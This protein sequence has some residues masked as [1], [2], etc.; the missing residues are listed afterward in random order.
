M[1]G[2]PDARSAMA[3]C[4]LDPRP[5]RSGVIPFSRLLRLAGQKRARTPCAQISSYTAPAG[6]SHH[7]LRV[8]YWVGAASMTSARR[9][10]GRSKVITRLAELETG[11]TA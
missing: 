9:C 6:S 7:L 4:G 3:C 10:G 8:D 1:M 2:P 11:P 5:V